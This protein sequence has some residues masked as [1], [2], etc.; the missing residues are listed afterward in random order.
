[1]RLRSFPA[2]ATLAALALAACGGGAGMPATAVGPA[3]TALQRPAW[4]REAP[5]TV[6]AGVYVGQANGSTDGVVFGFHASERRNQPPA[7][8]IPGQN[9][10]QSQ[11]AADSAG[12]V[13]LPDILTSAVNIYAPECGSLIA[14]VADP[15]GA[16]L[17]VAVHGG[18]FYAAGGQAVAVCTQGGCSTE[19]TDASIFQLE[20]AA[21]DSHG[22][23]WASYYSNSNGPSLIVW[24]GGAMPGR[25]VRGYVNQNTPGGLLFDRRDRLI[26]VQTL[27]AH[28]YAYRCDAS[29]ARCRNTGTFGLQGGSLFG[30][31]NARN[32]NFQA[33]DYA[34]DSIDVYAY[35]GFTYEYSYDRGLLSGSAVQGIVQ[36]H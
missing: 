10:D 9:F 19:L 4:W 31:L 25:I 28:V 1:M 8:S 22:N 16:P 13:Y 35:P 33:T 30:A 24:P 27:F 21:V 6:R 5:A 3:R 7:C 34:N 32:S 18:T 20:T 23:V 11:I 12:N 15:Y 17:D 29:T 14:S 2:L 26:S 36:T